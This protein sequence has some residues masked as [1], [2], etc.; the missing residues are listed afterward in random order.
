MIDTG[1]INPTTPTAG[2]GGTN[3]Y[4][5][6]SRAL[7]YRSEPFFRRLQQLVGQGRD[8]EAIRANE[9]LTYSS[10]TFGDPPT[11]IPRSYLGEPTK[12][13]LVHAGFEQLHVHHLHGGGTRWRL[14][15]GADNTDMSGGLKKVPIQNAKSI[16][17]DSQTVSPRESFNLE[18]ECGAGG[19]QQ[20]A[21]DF[22]YHCHIAHHYIAGMWG[23]WRVFDT[24]QAGL[25]PLPGRSRTGERGQRRRR[26]S[27]GRSRARRSS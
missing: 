23:I 8:L 21:G 12:T 26:C 14:N 24:Q 17:L 6:G 1:A 10:Y 18:H 19:C 3:A 27:A 25:A 2:G 11:P 15:P 4:R 5:P 20:A 22:L 9:S 16:R 7:N 13:R